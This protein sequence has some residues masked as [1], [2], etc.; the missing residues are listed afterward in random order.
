MI[1][2][3]ESPPLASCLGHRF[4]GQRRRCPRRSAKPFASARASG[5]RMRSRRMRIRQYLQP[6][7]SEIIWE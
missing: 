3:H 5:R 2:A 6:S 7:K 1:T 4:I